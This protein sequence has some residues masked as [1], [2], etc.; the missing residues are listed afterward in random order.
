[1]S[2]TIEGIGLHSGQPVKATLT[3]APAGSGITLLHRGK[4]F[5]ATIK[6]LQDTNR[7]TSLAGLAVVEHFL[8]A[9]YGLGVYDLELTAEGDELPALD[10]SAL[11]WVEAIEKI[12]TGNL[13][14]AGCVLN[15]PVIIND[16]AA[17]L[18]AFPY[19]GFKVDFMVNFEGIGEQRLVFDAE[20]MDYRSEIAPARTFGYLAEYEELKQHRLALGASYDNA[21]VLGPGGY[22]NQPRFPDELV[23]HKI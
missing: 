20:R 22:V 2:V 11:P 3:P 7:G 21:L 1:M 17:S 16:G 23:R 12:A 6:N 15:S 5:A 14:V 9:A 19:D 18:A 13:K 10:G 8:S 4:R